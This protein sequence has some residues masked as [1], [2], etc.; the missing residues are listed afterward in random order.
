MGSIQD[1]TIQ[2]RQRSITILKEEGIAG[3][4]KRVII[5]L[6]RKPLHTGC[7]IVALSLDHLIRA[8]MPAIDVVI[9][10][11]KATDDNDLRSQLDRAADD[12]GQSCDHAGGR[13]VHPDLGPVR[14]QP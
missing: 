2:F 14:Q 11:I 7:C 12:S 5:R 9:D 10:Q 3:L 13:L 4:I 1:V 6:S 8:P